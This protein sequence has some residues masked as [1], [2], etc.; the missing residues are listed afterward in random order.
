MTT[1]NTRKVSL[2]AY[3]KRVLREYERMLEITGL[4]PSNA[5]DLAEED[6]KH[7][8]PML[9]V[10]TDQAVRSDVIYEY[11]LIDVELD[12]IIYH[13]F[14]GRGKKFDAA[15]R[16]KRYNTLRLIM[17]KMYL[18]QKLDVIRSF[19]NIPSG[20][21]SKIAAI[22]DIRNSL[23]HTFFISDLKKSK[24]RY[25]GYN[26]FKREGLE[27]FQADVEKVRYFF[28]PWLRKIIEEE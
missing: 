20:I 13:H 23:A 2:T 26:I 22:N 5:L 7:L 12:F 14:F 24:R 1:V 6:P 8:A 3:Q 25:R 18:M 27:A 15:K 4:N 9:R 19:K 28:M 16:T 17:Q 21:A 11:T 10:M